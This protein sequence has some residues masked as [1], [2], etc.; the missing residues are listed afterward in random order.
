MQ[1]PL[2][3]Y[4]VHV[5]YSRD[6]S[7]Y[8]MVW[9][10][11][12]LHP[13]ISVHYSVGEDFYDCSRIFIWENLS[14][15]ILVEILHFLGTLDT[16]FAAYNY[17]NKIPRPLEQYTSREYQYILII[18]FI[19]WRSASKD[20]IKTVFFILLIPKIKENTDQCVWVGSRRGWCVC[21]GRDGTFLRIL[22]L[23][24]YWPCEEP[25]Y[26]KIILFKYKLTKITRLT[27]RT[28]LFYVNLLF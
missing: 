21:V 12:M 7:S 9:H 17:T 14:S 13:R 18:F 10:G 22:V 11:V 27:V 2:A 19:K 28:Q 20:N 15:M 6:V 4:L 8:N 3:Q 5:T 23:K 26:N 24:V 25:K 16:V 1:N